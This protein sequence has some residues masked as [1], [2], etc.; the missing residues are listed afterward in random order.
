MPDRVFA[1]LVITRG[2][3]FGPVEEPLVESLDPGPG[4]AAPDAI[5]PLRVAP[6]ELRAGAGA[7]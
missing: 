2:Y 3:G 4:I 6:V 5:V 1:S 7:V